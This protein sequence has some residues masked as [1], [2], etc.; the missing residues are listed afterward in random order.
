MLGLLIGALLMNSPSVDAQNLPRAH[1][2]VIIR[3]GDDY[4]L[5]STHGGLNIRRSADLKNWQRSGVVFETLPEWIEKEVPGCRGLWA[6]DITF[7]NGEY[8]IYYSASTFGKNRSCIG[9][10]S[11]KTLDSNSPDYKWID[12]GKVVESR[13]ED[14]FNAI[15]AAVVTDEQGVPWMSFGSFWS[16][17][18]MVR[19]DPKTG[20][21]ADDQL[22]AIASRPRPGAIEA[23]F[24][25]RRNEWY[26][27][28]VS[29][30]YCCKGAESTYNIRIGRSKDITGPYLDRDGKPMMEGGGS[31]LLEGYDHIRGPGHCGILEDNGKD[32]LVHH[33]YDANDRGVSKLHIRPLTWMEDGWCIVGKP[34]TDEPGK[35]S[36]P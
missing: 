2:P 31:V 24:I 20:L 29:F 16:G 36:P 7:I 12:H 6:P 8:R 5:F 23:P 35:E 4:Y 11:N 17:I 26:Y 15:D 30:D 3:C 14:D 27:L 22:H 32:Y 9:L 21:R 28:L 10:V 13:P 19:L 25:L 33:F 1:D 18:K 34:I